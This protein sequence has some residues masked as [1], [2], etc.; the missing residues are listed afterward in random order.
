MKEKFYRFILKKS[1]ISSFN[2]SILWIM[3]AQKVFDSQE[4]V[5]RIQEWGQ[6]P[7]TLLKLKTPTHVLSSRFCEIFK[8]TTKSCFMLYFCVVII[9]FNTDLY[10]SAFSTHFLRNKLF[11]FLCFMFFVCC[12]FKF[13]VMWSSKT[14]S[15]FSVIIVCITFA[16]WFWSH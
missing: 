3:L 9:L 4:A 2:I 11:V 14:F 5:G 7:A 13:D 12:V 15:N 16:L 6:G 1:F 8:R 10:K